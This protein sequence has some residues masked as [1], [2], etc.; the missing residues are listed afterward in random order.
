[1]PFLSHLVSFHP[2]HSGGRLSCEMN[3]QAK[4]VSSHHRNVVLAAGATGVQEDLG[5]IFH[6]D[7]MKTGRKRPF[8]LEQ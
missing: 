2:A 6:C 5:R 3:V 7:Q 4:F 8:S 1:M